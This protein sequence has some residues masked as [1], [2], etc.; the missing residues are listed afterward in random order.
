MLRYLKPR[1]PK[2]G[3][4]PFISRNLRAEAQALSKGVEHTGVGGW[5]GGGTFVQLDSTG[6]LGVLLGHVLELFLG[7]WLNRELSWSHIVPLSLVGS[8]LLCRS[9]D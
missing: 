7:C 2:I 3:H 4:L 1:C 5:G 6:Q 9:K 8:N